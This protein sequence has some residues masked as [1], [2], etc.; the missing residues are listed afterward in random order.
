MGGDEARAFEAYKSLLQSGRDAVDVALHFSALARARL[1]ADGARALLRDMGAQNPSLNLAAATL[2][3]LPRRR[4]ALESFIA[5]HP[6]YG[7]GYATLARE[8]RDDTTY[9]EPLRDRLREH[10]LLGHFLALDAQGKLRKS[11]INSAVLANWI[12]QAERRAAALEDSL[13]GTAAEPTAIFSRSNFSWTVNFNMPEEPTEVMYRLGEGGAY[14]S[15][16]R[17]DANNSRTGRKVVRT[18]ISLSFETPATTI[19]LKYSDARGREAGPFQ[20]PFD[21]HAI[22]LRQARAA[23]DDASSDWAMFMTGSNAIY[24]FFNTPI[25]N[26]CA[27]KKLEYGFNGPPHETIPVPRCDFYNPS[28][29]PPDS[30]PAVI[31]E[32]DVKTVSVRITFIDGTVETRIFGRPERR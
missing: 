29:V 24:V 15:A 22:I 12:D 18:Y 2:A 11:F 21:P 32:P 26:R 4:E 13:S 8:Y 5:A 10:E 14:T 28:G 16:G 6:D 1:G 3:E 23:L 25:E 31:M 27:I 19:F 30:N 20:F 17:L 9:Q 7:P